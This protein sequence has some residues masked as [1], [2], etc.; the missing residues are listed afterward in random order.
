MKNKKRI[1]EGYTLRPFEPV[2]TFWNYLSLGAIIQK[3]K[4][5]AE[6]RYD[7]ES[8][9]NKIIKVKITIEEIK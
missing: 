7:A 1:F 5:E 6:I 4:Y 2:W 8:R 3:N 9:M